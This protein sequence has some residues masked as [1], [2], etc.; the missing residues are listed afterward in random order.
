MR[1][2]FILLAGLVAACTP[3]TPPPAAPEPPAPAPAPVEKPE[4]SGEAFAA[5]PRALLPGGDALGCEARRLDGWVQVSCE[6]L[7]YFAALPF[8]VDLRPGSA[9]R[10]VEE[11][12]GRV[13]LR[14]R[15]QPGAQVNALISW[16]PHLVALRAGWPEGQPRPARVGELVGAP[17]NDRDTWIQAMCACTPRNGPGALL[18]GFAC[19]SPTLDV[20]ETVPWNPACIRLLQGEDACQRTNE[21][22]TLEP[23]HIKLCGPGE[24]KTGGH[25]ITSCLRACSAEEPCPRGFSCAA[26]EVM[27]S[28]ELVPGPSVCSPTDAAL[29]EH[30]AAMAEHLIT[31]LGPGE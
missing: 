14:Y 1:E 25:P 2:A 6:G 15:E 5:A 13:A 7:S 29:A 24:V 30:T 8:R 3:D 4:P 21:C 28:G 22:L 9:G 23:S 18:R 31:V 12:L 20:D 16:F 10:V 17:E 26:S 19:E 27:K 11:R